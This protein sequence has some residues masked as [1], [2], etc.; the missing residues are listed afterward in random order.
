MVLFGIF[1]IYPILYSIYISF[2]DWNLLSSVKPFIGLGNYFVI[3][4]DSVFLIALGNTLIYV[5]ATV[6]F[7]FVISLSLALLFNNK[8]KFLG[9]F[10]AIYFLPVITS[11][12]AV[13]M[14]WKWIYQPGFGLLNN[15]LER[16]R[17]PTVS[18]LQNNHTALIC[19]IVVGVWASVGYYMVI[20][21]AALKQIPIE[22]YEAARIDG[23]TS[24]GYFRYITIP[25]LRRTSLF[26]LVMAIINSMQ[27]FTLVFIMT[28]GGPA[29]ATN[30]V[31]LYIYD[32]VFSF[33][34]FGQGAAAS[35]VLFLLILIFTLTQFRFFGEKS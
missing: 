2:F 25:S 18:W 7:V 4:K 27:M 19:I 23:A 29:D 22:Y 5:I 31:V 8:I 34:R 15:V 32:V 12:V 10:R 35:V 24:A 9:L 20:F 11:L 30:V 28:R 3:F 1:R 16:L 33:L 17:I 21:I 26:V 14:V 6:P 13:A